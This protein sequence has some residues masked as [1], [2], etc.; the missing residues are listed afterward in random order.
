MARRAAVSAAR[1][2]AYG[3]L[4][5]EPL[6]PAVPDDAHERTAP[7]GSVSVITVLLNVEVIKAFPTGMFFFSLRL[8]FVFRS[9]IR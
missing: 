1:P 7:V 8:V 5:R 2:A 6:K 3:V 4:L 9:A